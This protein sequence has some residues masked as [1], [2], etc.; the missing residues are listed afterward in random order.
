MAAQQCQ[1]W[2]S[3]HCLLVEPVENASA[4]KR[5]PPPFVCQGIE[6]KTQSRVLRQLVQGG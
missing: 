2:V 4:V 5:T 1:Y 6:R 3:L